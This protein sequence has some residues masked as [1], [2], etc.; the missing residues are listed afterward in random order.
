MIKTTFRFLILLLLLAV[1]AIPAP[2]PGTLWPE[3]IYMTTIPLKRAG[4]LFILEANIDGV[5]GNFIF[6]T[7]S[8]RLVLNSTYFRNYWTLKGTEAGGVT[9]P[10]GTVRR[11]AVKKLQ[12][13]GLNYLNVTADVADLGHIENRRGV[14][15]LGLFGSN[16][17]RDMEVVIDIARNQLRLYRLDRSGKRI[18]AA[19]GRF[20]ADLTA[21]VRTVQDV[22]FISATIGQK[23]LNFCLDTGAESNILSS[24][25]PRKVMNTVSILGRSDLRGVSGQ[26]SDMLY[27]ALGDFN[28]GERKI[29]GMQTLIASMDN[30]SAFYD[31]QVDGMLGYDFFEQGEISIN[32]V[33]Q[34]M[35]IV[36]R[37]GGAK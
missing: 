36:F 17:L 16:M 23:E 34:E 37:K 26:G 13:S 15:V 28:L 7:G 2:S 1:P 8:S 4:R 18:G 12:V 27:A 24:S 6:D 10:A 19:S 20:E 35:G 11:A 33:T 21:K 5:A 32:L 3:G 25:A 22:I 29:S 14:K 31:C 30:M 9:G